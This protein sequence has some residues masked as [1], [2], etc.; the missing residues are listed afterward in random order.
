MPLA[1]R[2]IREVDGHLKPFPHARSRHPSPQ[3]ATTTGPDYWGQSDR[4]S[5]HKGIAQIF[6]PTTRKR[7]RNETPR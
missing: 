2:M 7:L 5:T 4:G 6:R 3:E 1:Y